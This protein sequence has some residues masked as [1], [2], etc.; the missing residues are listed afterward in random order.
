MQRFGLPSAGIPPGTFLLSSDT[1]FTANIL[2]TPVWV[3]DTSLS[4][5]LSPLSPEL[6]TVRATCVDLDLVGLPMHIPP[7]VY[8]CTWMFFV[9]SRSNV[10]YILLTVELNS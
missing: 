6:V 3:F 9:C 8:T 4:L 2:G 1:Q 7:L 10:D 5:S